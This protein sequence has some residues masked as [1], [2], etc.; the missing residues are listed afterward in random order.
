[1]SANL[2]A[3]KQNMTITKKNLKQHELIGLHAEVIDASNKASI[4][5]KGN[6]VNETQKMLVFDSGDNQYASP[7][8]KRVF[9]R[10]SAFKVTLPDKKEVELNGDDIAFR[11]WERISK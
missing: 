6:I 9:K 2:V 11:P 3:K 8:L 1:V 5:L 10:G 7:L 4:G